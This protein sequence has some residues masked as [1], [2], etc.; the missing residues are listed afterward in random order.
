MLYITGNL[1]YWIANKSFGG[2]AAIHLILSMR[3]I[4]SSIGILNAVHDCGRFVRMP[5]FRD[6]LVWYGQS[7][8]PY[9][10]DIDGSCSV[11][12][13][14]IISEFK[15]DILHIFD[16]NPWRAIILDIAKRMNIITIITPLDYGLLCARTTLVRGDGRL[17]TGRTTFEECKYCL[18]M[19]RSRLYTL[20]KK[21]AYRI[22]ASTRIP[23][24]IASTSNDIKSRV[25]LAAQ[26]T[27]TWP[28]YVENVDHWIAPSR[29]MKRV[30]CTNGVP[31]DRVT[32]VP[33]G[34][35]APAKAINPIHK[36]DAK[37]I[38]GFAGRP[39]Y[40]KGIHLLTDGFLAARKQTENAKLVIFGSSLTGENN[41][42]GR[43][44]LR[45][46][47]RNAG[48]DV[49]FGSY[50]GTDPEAIATAQNSIDVMVVP[51]IWYDNLPLVVVESLAH[52]TPV[53]ASLHSS[54]AEPIEDGRNGLLFD[55][56]AK[57]SLA[58]KMIQFINGFKMPQVQYERTCME[59]AMEIRNVY[60]IL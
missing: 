58:D 51:S 14:R 45:R 3:R 16:Y 9:S 55:A 46:L 28:Q 53:I 29:A 50:D 25:L 7:L 21:L 24:R 22:P 34:Y 48:S 12:I 31:E 39:M 27:E 35:D 30:L 17:C 33:Y 20:I 44:T 4:N 6:M 40:E 1:H 38:F 57:D 59:E 11:G 26:R 43:K 10:V 18:L 13:E 36:G 60:A 37:I 23:E 2:F 42:H 54:A 15:P 19:G 41:P 49:T 5:A 52:G 8:N 47:Y 56:F 32:H